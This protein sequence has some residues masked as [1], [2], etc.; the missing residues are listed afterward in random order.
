MQTTLLHLLIVPCW[1]ALV[2]QLANYWPSSTLLTIPIFAGSHTALMLDAR[3]TTAVLGG[4]LALFA[5]FV[6]L[7]LF[8]VLLSL[9]G[10]LSLG[11]TPKSNDFDAFV[12][13]MSLGVYCTGLSIASGYCVGRRQRDKASQAASSPLE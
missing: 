2:C 8:V 4:G 10:L 3:W 7:P 9:F 1:S 6:L 5:T 13:H 12:V 11:P